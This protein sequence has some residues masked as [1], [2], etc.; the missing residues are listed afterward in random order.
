MA[1]TTKDELISALGR[2]L[3]RSDLTAQAADFIALAEAQ[4]NRVLRVRQMESRS[5]SNITPGDVFVSL[6]TD[7]LEEKSIKVSDG[8]CSWDLDPQPAEVLEAA[9]PRTGRPTH[10]ALVGDAIHY[11]PSPD[12]N[13][14]ATLIYWARIPALTDAQ[15]TNWLLTK[16][17]DAYLYGALTHAGSYLEDD[18]GTASKFETLY[19]A[20]IG[21]LIGEQRTKVG[22]LTTDHP[23]SMRGGRFN[24]RTGGY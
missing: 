2:W 17:P 14:S 19:G 13:Y 20:A 6:P 16:A 1:I 23:S 24:I 12:G 9:P 22:K 21:G 3:D 7:F 11:Y 10:Y 5:I 4:M 8:S 15:P 18:T